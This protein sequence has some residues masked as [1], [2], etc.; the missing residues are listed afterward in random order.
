MYIFLELFHRFCHWWWKKQITLTIGY[1]RWGFD[2]FKGRRRSQVLNSMEPLYNSTS[3]TRSFHQTRTETP[4]RAK[5]RSWLT[6]SRRDSV[7]A[8]GNGEL[9]ELSVASIDAS[10]SERIHWPKNLCF[11]EKSDFCVRWLAPMEEIRIGSSRACRV[12]R[13][14]QLTPNI[15]GWQLINFFFLL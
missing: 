10:S 8:G 5:R 9:G 6:A 4:F 12:L 7:W 15:S 14:L 3:S 1:L 13:C 2:V 11:H